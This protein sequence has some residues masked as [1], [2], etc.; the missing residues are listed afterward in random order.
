MTALPI[1][2]ATLA[3]LV[4]GGPLCGSVETVVAALARAGERVVGSGSSKVRPGYL[5]LW[6]GPAGTWTAVLLVPGGQA[7]ILDLGDAWQPRPVAE[8][9]G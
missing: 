2:G 8:R 5:Q 4:Q 9:E 1:I 3:V 6:A 7:C